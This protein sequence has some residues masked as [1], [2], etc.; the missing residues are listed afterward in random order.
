MDLVKHLL[1]A[2]TC[3]TAGCGSNPDGMNPGVG[4]AVMTV[5]AVGASAHSR[6][7]GG[8]YAVCVNGTSCNPQTGYCQDDPC[9][10][11]C[12][13]GEH[14]EVESLTG[15]HCVADLTPMMF[16]DAGPPIAP[17]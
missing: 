2:V 5:L 12:R 15:P 16:A 13:A 4:A 10:G 17:P 3:A 11:A 9:D 1:L 8:C 14:C 6:S 7:Q